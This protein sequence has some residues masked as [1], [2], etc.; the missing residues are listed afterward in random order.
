MVATVR[1]PQK[2]PVFGRH[3]RPG[4][5]NVVAPLDA[6]QTVDVAD[7]IGL[8]LDSEDLVGLNQLAF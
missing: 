1:N 8:L 3:R 5:L 6:D 7:D 2:R 4:H